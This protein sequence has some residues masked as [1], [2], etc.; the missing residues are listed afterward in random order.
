MTN[1]P[2]TRNTSAARPISPELSPALAELLDSDGSPDEA[3]R[4]IG[5]YMALREEAR[6]AL[7]ALKAVAEWKAGT[8]GVKAVIGK[9]F[10]LYPQP[11]RSEGEW[12]AFWEDYQD[13]LADVPLPC[14]EAA[15]RAWV[16]RPTSEFLPK[17]GQ[18]YELAYKTVS[19]SLRRYQR[20]TR[21]LELID[22]PAPVREPI[23]EG[24]AIDNAA[25]IRRMFADFKTRSVMSDERLNRPPLPSIAGKPD[26]TGITPEMRAVLNRQRGL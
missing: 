22:H 14:L 8:E 24:V 7:P 3:V 6:A 18:L 13:V 15:M 20:V 26:S 5:A 4:Q 10:V 1:L 19:R 17:P 9:R 23:P 25:E 16:A 2:T 21:A 11:E 12:N